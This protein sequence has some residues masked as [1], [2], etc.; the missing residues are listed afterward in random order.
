MADIA[1][2]IQLPP[3]LFEKA[4]GRYE[5]VR[6]YA[7][8]DGSPLR[9]RILRFY[10]QGSMSIDATISNRGT[11]DEYDLDIVAELDIDPASEPDAVLDVLA[12]ALD[13]YPTSEKVDRQTRCVTL[14]Y[15]DRMHLDVT[16]AARLPGTVERESHIF[17]A[18]PDELA[19]EHYHVPDERLRLRRV[20]QGADAA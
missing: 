18:S 11:D 3:S 16:P 1:V 4:T 14:R 20:V 7:Q 12:D 2:N 8:R 10:P 13:G 15:A 9:G 6:D 5:A 19:S 17:H